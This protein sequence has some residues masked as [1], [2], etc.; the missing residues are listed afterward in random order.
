M[1][2]EAGEFDFNA[3]CDGICRKL[4]ERHPHV[5]GQT[6]VSGADEVLSNWEA[7]KQKTKKQE[8]AA[9][10]LR[11]VPKVFPAL[12]R[13][14][15]VQKRAAKV[16][17]DWDDASGALDKLKEEYAEL[18]QAAAQQDRQHTQE[19]LGDLLFAAV[20]VA[21]FTGVDAEDALQAAS[22]KFIRRFAGVEELAAERGIEM[23]KASLAQLDAL[24]DEIK[25]RE[26]TR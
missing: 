3:V 23:G 10:T 14:Q 16:G 1:A 4:I 5:F 22:E 11:A 17:F 18:C 24:W 9:E 6:E 2:E 15:K 20:N 21:R 26:P 13:A 19:E 12:M 8:T 7:I 25:L